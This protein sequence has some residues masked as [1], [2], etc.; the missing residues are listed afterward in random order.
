[1]KGNKRATVG[2]YDEIPAFFIVTIAIVIFFISAANAYE[3]YDEQRKDISTLDDT[4]GFL[5]SVR[6]SPL[7]T[8]EGQ[9]GL[10]DSSKVMRLNAENVSS[11]ISMS[12]GTFFSIRLLDL[13]NFSLRYDMNVTNADGSINGDTANS[14]HGVLTSPVSIWVND[15]EVHPGQL[16]VEIWS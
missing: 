12:G 9:A 11:H 4:Q 10:F 3:N 2:F 13:G 5:Q 14:F 7:L 15:E 16:K 1:M 6:S 8:H